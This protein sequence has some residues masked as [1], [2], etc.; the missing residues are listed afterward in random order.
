MKMQ[1]R[2]TAGGVPYFDTFPGNPAGGSGAQRLHRRFLSGKTRGK[3]L[4]RVLF[5]LAIP[6]LLLGKDAM[7]KAI[8]KARNG[9]RYAR[10]FADVHSGSDNH[11]ANSTATA[12]ATT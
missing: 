10:N 12:K 2:A 4:D 3:A 8:A 5:A 7:Q 9:L 1:K 6:N 11:Q